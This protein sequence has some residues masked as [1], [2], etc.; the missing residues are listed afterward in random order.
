MFIIANKSHEKSKTSNE[1]HLLTVKFV[2][3]A[4]K[5]CVLVCAI[6]LNYC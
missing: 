1:T 2:N 5:F 3:P 4:T 6:V